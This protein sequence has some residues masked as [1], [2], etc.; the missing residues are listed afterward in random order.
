MASSLGAMLR[1]SLRRSR[2]DW[3]IVAAAALICLLAATLLAAGSIYADSV[4]TA[5]LHRVL[6]DARPADAGVEVTYRALPGEVGSVDA[7]VTT[8]LGATLDPPGGEIVRQARSDSFAL[9]DQPAGEVRELAV[10][11][12]AEGLADHAVLVEGA[13]PGS[14]ASGAGTTAASPVPVAIS[15]AVA[16]SLGLHVGDELVLVS[17]AD[18]A[19]STSVRIAAIFRIAEPSEDFWWDEPQ[20]VDGVV[21]SARFTTHGPFFTTLDDLL[22]RAT[23]GRIEIRW[24]AVPA[25]AAL[26]VRDV[27]SLAN[28]VRGLKDRLS[29]TL[30][31]GVGVSTGLP[32]ILTDADRSL[33]VSRAGV[34]L[35]TVQLVVLA[36][37]A[38]LLSASLLI[39]RRRIDTAMLRSRGAG[40]WRV[41]ALTA[42]EAAVL[43]VPIALLAPWLAATALRVFNLVGPLADAGLAIEPRVTLDAYVA[44]GAAALVCL[45]ALVLPAAR[46]SRQFATVHGAVARGETT[47]IGQRLGIDVALLAVAGLG[48]WQLRQYGA[49]L[50]RSVQGTLGLDPLLIAT[51]ALGL[52]AGGVAALRIVPLLAQLAERATTRRRGLVAALGARQL[53]RRPLRYTRAALLLM[54]AMAM[55]V[56]AVCYTATWSSSQ[57]DQARFQVGAD[58]RVQ[59]GRQLESMPTWALDAAYGSLPG[60]VDRLPVARETVRVGRSTAGGEIL[61]ADAG[62][63]PAVVR[64]R[65]DLATDSLATLSAPLV[66]ARPDVQGV[67]L[68]DGTRQLR[69]DVELAITTIERQELDPATGLQVEVPA[70]RTEIRDWRGLGLS[71]VVRDARG[72]LYRFTGGSGTLGD[73]RNQLVVSLGTAGAPDGA[74]FASPLELV[75]LEV[76]VGLPAAYRATEATVT[77]GTL[78]A[79]GAD[80]AWTPASLAL[81]TGWRSTSAYFGRPHQ[82]VSRFLRGDDLGAATGAPGLPYL[83]GVDQVGRGMILTFA[84]AALATATDQPVP[85]VASEA[86]LAASASR[87][88]DDVPLTIGGVRR[89]VHLAGSVRAFP[90]TDPR[91]PVALMDLATLSLLQYEGNDAVEPVR[92]WWLAVDDGAAGTIADALGRS[93][94]ASAGVETIEGRARALATDPV[95]LGIIGALAI[96]FA[97][98]ALFA[99]VG[100]VVSAAVSARERITEFALLQA[101]GLS[102]RQLSVWLSLESAALAAV[103]LV[104]G[105]LLGLA[106]AWVVLPFITV[107]AGAATPFPPVVVAV[108]W[109]GVAILEA[110]SLVALGGTVVLLSWLL[111]RLR[112]ASVLRMSAD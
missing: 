61:A 68:P 12:Y 108:P 67:P 103:S 73:E 106:M 85:V 46:S 81:A 75:A 88:G 84:P 53:A 69:V 86:F 47:S 16:G 15:T 3:P 48:F 25:A 78:S 7:A 43:T 29:A 64:L 98:A 19:F 37:Y 110:S 21:T 4:S 79:A 35:V 6:A 10:L 34:L 93:P 40:R 28:R 91:E 49:P 14:G 82:V 13:W 63:V 95:A 111:G 50:T 102:S 5:G 83:P 100:F 18:A 70:T 112:L 45:A 104:V 80:G 109:A 97:A 33:L 87:V 2:A 107:T 60:L 27:G 54:L 32:G 17:R 71:A 58:V 66:A 89:T 24:H 57:A 72:I 41:V 8:Q 99:I 9:P 30:G 44:A 42:I 94:F 26:D 62:I 31:D 105:S 55:G 51:P 96:G 101:L 36:A 20:A 23:P 59:A 65:G 74:A 90:G 22:A 11:G 76:A 1:I 77:V 39:E 56:F 92:E 52:L 38:V